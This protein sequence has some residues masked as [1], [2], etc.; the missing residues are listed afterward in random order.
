[1]PLSSTPNKNPL[2]ARDCRPNCGECIAL[3]YRA[4][5]LEYVA[6]WAK[7][8]LRHTPSRFVKFLAEP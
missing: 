8:V 1:M 7:R 2:A 5:A 4:L 3:L 6:E